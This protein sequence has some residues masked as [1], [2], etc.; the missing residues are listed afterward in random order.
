MV[1]EYFDRGFGKGAGALRITRPGLHCAIPCR[2]TR[3]TQRDRAYNPQAPEYIFQDLE[4]IVEGPVNILEALNFLE[5]TED[6][7]GSGVFLEAPQSI[8]ETLENILHDLECNLP[9]PE[10]D[11]MDV[12]YILQGRDHVQEALDFAPEDLE[13]I[14]EASECF[15]DTPEY[16]PEAPGVVRRIQNMFN[17]RLNILWKHRN[18][19]STGSPTS[20]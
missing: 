19:Y 6:F 11:L 1:R 4:Y 17:R 12:V 20:Y 2:S 16:L 5:A 15:P 10:Y 7:L 14:L 3:I 8:A 9:A 18:I 13:Y